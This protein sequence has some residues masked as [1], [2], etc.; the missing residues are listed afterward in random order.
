MGGG[1]GLCLS[2]IEG[3]GGLCL[4]AIEGFREFNLELKDL[5]SGCPLV[6]QTL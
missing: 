6:K 1:G 5:V 4:S 3:L 2:A